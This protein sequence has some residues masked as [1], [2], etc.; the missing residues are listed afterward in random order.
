MSYN[1]THGSL[2]C[3]GGGWTGCGSYIEQEQGENVL[4]LRAAAKE[5]GWTRVKG[6]DNKM[7]DL[8]PNCSLKTTRTH[9]I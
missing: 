8:C 7:L 3:D 6:D 4:S 9:L 5:D 2:D 1:S